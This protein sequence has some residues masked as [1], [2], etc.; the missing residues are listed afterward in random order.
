MSSLHI[1][2]SAEPIYHI[3]DFVIT[4]SMFTSVIVSALIIAFA[5]AANAAVK[6]QNGKPTRFQVFVEFI[7][8]SLH[9]LVQGITENKAKTALFFPLIATF[10]IFILVNN[11]VGLLPGVGTVGFL[12]EEAGASTE[13]V[14]TRFKVQAST[15]AVEDHGIEATGTMEAGSPVQEGTDEDHAAESGVAEGEAVEEH[16]AGPVFVPY[17]RA[18]TADLNTNIALALISVTMTQIWGVKFLKLSYFKKYI[19]I[20]NPINF[21]VGMLELILELAKIVSFAFRL[22]GNI[23]AG[24]VLLAVIAFLIPVIAPMPFYGMELFVGF[25]QALV[26]SMLSLVFFN[27]AT[28]GHHDEH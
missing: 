27:M 10:F 17:L 16:G 14:D 19:D 6:H 12:E 2:I 25:I 15:P 26:F 4:N 23:F 21:F 22:F 20:S 24:E 1:S 3:G 11:W 28:M 7:I 8:E 18:A 5:L 13:H 9:N